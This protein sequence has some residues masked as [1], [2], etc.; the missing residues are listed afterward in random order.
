MYILIVKC[1]DLTTGFTM[2]AAQSTG[3]PDGVGLITG[4]AGPTG[5]R[6]FSPPP[7]AHLNIALHPDS[8][9]ISTA[10]EEIWGREVE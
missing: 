1:A 4:L 9:P 3:C 5:C 6:I 2:K 10:K 8:E 7:P